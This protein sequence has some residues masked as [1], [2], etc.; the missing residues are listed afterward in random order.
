MLDFT[1]ADTH[2][3]FATACYRRSNLLTLASFRNNRVGNGL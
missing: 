2:V 3:C 1:I